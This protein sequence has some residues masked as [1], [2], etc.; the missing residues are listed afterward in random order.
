MG[1]IFSGT[2]GGW[3]AD[4]WGRKFSLMF[5]GIPILIGYLLISYAHFSSISRDFMIFLFAGRFMTGVG[6][7]VVATVVC[8]S[9]KHILFT[10]KWLHSHSG[11]VYTN[12]HNVAP[13]IAAL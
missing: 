11:P 3:T 6:M 8:V 13:I 7:G 10:P 5:S 2:V 4:R 9:D 12:N 1:A